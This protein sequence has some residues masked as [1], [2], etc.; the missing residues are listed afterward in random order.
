MKTRV[1]KIARLPKI[2]RD[3]LNQQLENGVR[4][5][6]I[7]TWLNALPEVQKVLA[8]QFDGRPINKQNISEWR[9]DGYVDWARS[10]DGRQH[11]WEMMETAGKL[12]EARN[13]AGVDT[14]RYLGTILLIELF[15]ALD[16]LRDMK[17]CA[18]RRKLLRTLSIAISRLQ[19]DE[20]REK[21]LRLKHCQLLSPP[22]QV[23]RSQA[24]SNLRK[25][26][27]PSNPSQQPGEHPRPADSLRHLAEKL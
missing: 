16:E 13:H 17:D 22:G 12:T 24:G 5:S 27:S 8:E 6:D 21:L 14:S 19:T 26:I 23:P 10:R 18:E 1:G 2:L 7:L 20:S 25:K 9:H 4:A 15:D 3:Q 11:W